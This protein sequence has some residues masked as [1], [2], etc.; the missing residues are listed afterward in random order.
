MRNRFLRFLLL[1]GEENVW[2]RKWNIPALCKPRHQFENLS[3]ASESQSPRKWPTYAIKSIV[4]FIHYASF[5]GDCI[6]FACIFGTKVKSAIGFSYYWW[7][8]DSHAKKDWHTTALTARFLH[9]MFRCL[10]QFRLP[11]GFFTITSFWCSLLPRLPQLL[12]HSPGPSHHQNMPDIGQLWY[13]VLMRNRSQHFSAVD[14]AWVAPRSLPGSVSFG[15][16][17]ASLR[18]HSSFTDVFCFIYT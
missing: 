8:K 13:S 5:L 9:F 14:I 17:P 11:F 18:R 12:R 2:T 16:Y 7:K 4:E 6:N 3:T 1:D 10:R 15:S